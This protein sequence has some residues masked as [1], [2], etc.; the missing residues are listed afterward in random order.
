MIIIFIYMLL[1]Y[2]VKKALSSD[3]FVIRTLAMLNRYNIGLIL[4]KYRIPSVN[5]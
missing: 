1:P 2:S 5:H 4:Y 3:N